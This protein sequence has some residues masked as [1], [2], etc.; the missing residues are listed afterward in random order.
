MRPSE[1]RSGMTLV[2]LLVC[3]AILASLATSVA[4]ATSGMADRANADMANAQGGAMREAVVRSDGLN[5]ANDIGRMLDPAQPGEVGLFCSREFRRDA[6]RISGLLRGPI[7]PNNVGDLRLAP[8]YRQYSLYELRDSVTKSAERLAKIPAETAS[9][10][11]KNVSVGAGWR[12]PYCTT[13]RQD[14]ETRLLLDPF[15]GFWDCGVDGDMLTL[16]CY[17]RDRSMDSDIGV[18]TNDWRGTDIKYPVCLT[19]VAI[20]LLVRVNVADADPDTTVT[21][22]NIHCFA[23]RLNSEAAD[24]DGVCPMT[25]TAYVFRPLPAITRAGTSVEISD[26]MLSPGAWAVFVCSASGKSYSA[27]VSTL[28]LHRGNNS[29]D[30]PLFADEH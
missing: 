21:N 17:G 8:L 19:N 5:L 20:T 2:E 27:P 12:G 23:P 25:P 14:P 4:V 9:N 13:A 7:D 28:H 15:G 22:A 29:V 18:D 3:L 11:W 16:S 24:A 26:P 10:R 1:H 30:L 6:K